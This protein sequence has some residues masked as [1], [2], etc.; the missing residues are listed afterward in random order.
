VGTPH[1]PRDDELV[2]EQEKERVGIRA[3]K[4]ASMLQR[5]GNFQQIV[6]DDETEASAI[7]CRSLALRLDSLARS[8]QEFRPR[9]KFHEHERVAV[10]SMPN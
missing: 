8:S 5:S 10:L 3:C 9:V 4:I 7:I 1:P 6:P 2:D